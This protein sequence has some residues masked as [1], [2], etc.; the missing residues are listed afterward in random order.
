MNST[1]AKSDAL[2]FFGAT[3]D[4]A[5]KKVFP[6]IQYLIQHG[7][8]DVPIIGVAKSG[9]TLEQLRERA[10]DSLAK[11]GGVDEAAFAKLVARLRYVD[12][13]YNDPETFTQLRQALGQSAAPLHYLAIPPSLFGAVVQNLAS[14]AARTTRGSSSRSRSAATLRS[15][16]GAQPDPPRNVRR[17]ADLPDRP[18]RGQGAR[19]QHPVLPVRQPVPRADLEPRLHRE[20]ADHDGRELRRAGPRCRSTR[21]PA[22]SAT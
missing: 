20:H 12:G 6:A 3:G 21:R 1:P 11:H 2:V 17:V 4:L 13:D 19:A 18:L 7:H 16:R 10:R 15:A 5:Y 22:R 14:R 8:L 9:W